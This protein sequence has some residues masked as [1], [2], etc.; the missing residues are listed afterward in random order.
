MKVYDYT[1]KGNLVAVVTDGSAVLG[2]GD[3]GPR[4]ALPVMEGKAVLF[5]FYAGIEAFPICLATQDPDEIVAAVKHIAPTFGGINLEDIA[6]P[7]C[8]EIEMRLR[9]ELD[10]PVFHDDQHGTAVVV[11]AGLLNAMRLLNR[12]LDAA[13]IVICGAGAAGTAIAQLLLKRGVQDLLLIDVH[14]TVY[15]GREAGM[16]PVLAVLA[17]QTNRRQLTGHLAEALVGADVFI[18][19]SVGGVLKPEMMKKM[20][21]EPIIFALANPVPEIMPLEALEAGARIV[22]TGRSDFPNQVNNSLVFPGVFRGALDVRATTITIDMEL[23][24]AQALADVIPQ[25]ELRPDYIIPE[26]FDFRVPPSMAAAVARSAI[27][28]G[29][30]RVKRDPAAIARDTRAYLYEG[31]LGS[32]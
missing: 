9:T 24:A 17:R 15:E 28:V 20:A 1:A 22:A 3:L 14:G 25:G 8:F 31:Q 7:R 11:L 18:G 27:D 16:N 32:W 23:A 10:I 2:L 29:V 21:P 30:A 12:K 6:S 13:K 26:A 4:A 19:V 5:N